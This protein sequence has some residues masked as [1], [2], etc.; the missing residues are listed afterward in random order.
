MGDFMVSKLR[1]LI[2]AVMSVI[3][4]SAHA[5]VSYE[6][7]A[8]GKCLQLDEKGNASKI[9]ELKHCTGHN[10]KGS[11]FIAIDSS[12]RVPGKQIEGRS[13]SVIESFWRRASGQ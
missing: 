3:V 5:E 2:F 7:T 4:L 10:E 8:S 9:V 12:P 13:P 11:Q 1:V 6:F